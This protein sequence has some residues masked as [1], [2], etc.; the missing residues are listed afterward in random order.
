MTSVGT[1]IVD[2]AIG[3]AGEF[4]TAGV[5][6]PFADGRIAAIVTGRISGGKLME[7]GGKTGIRVNQKVGKVG[8]DLRCRGCADGFGDV[9]VLPTSNDPTEIQAKVTAA[10]QADPTIDTVLAPGAGPAGEPAAAAVVALGKGP[11][12]V[13][14][15]PF[16]LSVS[17]LESVVAVDAVFAIDLKQF[18]QGNL[19]VNFLALHA[20]YGLMPG[21]NVASGPNLITADRAG[22]VVELSAQGNLR[23]RSAG[24]G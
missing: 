6:L 15:A 5:T 17:C 3:V 10:L 21:G 13:K 24:G 4:E 22:Q 16:D 8:L 9:T 12:A 23:T 1:S 2:P 19:A 14:V 11:G 18:L 7:T 20:D